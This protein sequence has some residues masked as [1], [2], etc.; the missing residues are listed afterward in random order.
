MRKK[1]K[2]GSLDAFF[3]KKFRERG[4]VRA[5]EEIGP[6]MDIA[7][8][9]VEARHKAGLSQNELARKLGTTQSVISRIENG[10]QNLSV[11]VLAKIAEVLDCNLTVHLRPHRLAA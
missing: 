10:N 4:F 11:N 3:K 8:M 1:I 5:Y 2:T 9:I 7:M 6:L